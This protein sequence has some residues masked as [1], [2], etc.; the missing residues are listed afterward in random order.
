M[1]AA[2]WGQAIIVLRDTVV[3]GIKVEQARL[4]HVLGSRHTGDA[5]DTTLCR[6]WGGGVDIGTGSTAFFAASFHITI[7]IHSRFDDCS[8]PV[9]QH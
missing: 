1:A 7:I 4:S 5:A 9:V 6:E 2:A 8:H 3:V